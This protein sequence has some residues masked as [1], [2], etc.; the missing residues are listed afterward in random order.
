MKHSS[1][2]ANAESIIAESQRQSAVI[3]LPE[4]VTTPRRCDSDNVKTCDKS[5]R[6]RKVGGE[7]AQNTVL[8][9]NFL[10]R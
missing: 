6:R 8:P 1:R 5:H 2:A 9:R 4:D 3:L 10:S 7:L